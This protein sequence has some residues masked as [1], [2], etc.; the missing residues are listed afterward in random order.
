MSLVEA[1]NDGWGWTGIQAAQVHDQ[2]PMGHLIFSDAEEC[3]YHLDADGMRIETL[4]TADAV[5]AHFAAPEVQELWSGGALVDGARERCGIQRLDARGRRLADVGAELAEPRGECPRS[6]LC[7][8]HDA[9][10]VKAIGEATGNYSFVY[11]TVGIRQ[12]SQ[13]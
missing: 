5:Q 12:H 8:R 2:S 7:A 11:Q 3:F 4:G 10:D 13:I 9:E 1:I 6:R